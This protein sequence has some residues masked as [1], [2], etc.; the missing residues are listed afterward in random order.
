MQNKP[1]K[2]QE[3]IPT[4]VGEPAAAYRRQDVV[5]APLAEGWN[6]NVPFHG[7]QGEWCEHFHRIEDGKF[8]TLE[9]F[10]CKFE[11][12]KKEYL[13]NKLR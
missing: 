9:E 13:A 6:P 5:E 12:W 4:T 3:N 10:D 11:K 1:Y 7:T 2:I 8:M